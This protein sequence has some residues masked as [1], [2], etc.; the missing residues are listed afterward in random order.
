MQ[1]GRDHW[2]VTQPR[3][4]YVTNIKC[5][6][7]CNVVDF[8]TTLHWRLTDTMESAS[9]CWNLLHGWSGT[10]QG[11]G[12]PGP[13]RYELSR[14]FF[15][16]LLIR[17][18]A[19]RHRD[20]PR[21]M[22]RQQVWGTGL[23]SFSILSTHSSWICSM[24]THRVYYSWLLSEF[25]KF[26]LSQSSFEALP[27]A[28][29]LTRKW[30]SRQPFSYSIQSLKWKLVSGLYNWQCIILWVFSFDYFIEMHVVTDMTHLSTRSSLGL[31]LP[32]VS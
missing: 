18:P 24:T 9:M 27:W 16:L 20:E 2:Q 4:V 23:Y 26:K 25:T 3:R 8:S 12:S 32:P 19:C 15:G 6:F 21:S 14:F 22:T 28:S 10:T 17:F 11:I 29:M 7:Q 13:K 31:S 30:T 1:N 5:L